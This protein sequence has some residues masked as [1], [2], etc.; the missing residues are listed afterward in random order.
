MTRRSPILLCILIFMTML[1]LF[2]SCVSDVPFP[3]ENPSPSE[4]SS[5]TKEPAIDIEVPE[6]ISIDM[7]G[8]ASVVN[9]GS[10]ALKVDRY[11]ALDTNQSYAADQR[12][13]LING[14]LLV[15]AKLLAKIT[16]FTFDNIDG[17]NTATLTL[18][19]TVVTF[20]A[21][22]NKISIDGQEYTYPTIIKLE[23]SFLL[24]AQPFVEALGYTFQYD[25]T[26]KTY[27]ISNKTDSLTEEVRTALE[28]TSIQYDTIVY[29]YDDVECGQSGVGLYDKTPYEDRLVGIAY[30]TW[31]TTS[32]DWGNKTWDIPL[33]GKYTSNTK[34]IIRAHGQMLAEAGVDFIFIDW[35]NNTSYDPETMSAS[36]NDFRTIEQ[37]TDIIFEEWAKI[38]NAPKICIFVGPGHSGQENVDN[39]NHQ[40]KVDQVYRDY[41]D[42]PENKD[43]Y[44]YYKGKP[45]L[46]CYAATPTKYG[47][48]PEW[49]DER[50]TI[51]WMTGFV[52]QQSKLF[53]A[54]TK[55]SYRYWSWEERGEQTFTVVDGTVEA[56]TCCAASRKQSNP[57]DNNYIAPIPRNNG[58][59]LKQQFQRACDL[60][61]GVVV[62]VS[63]NEW[64]IGEQPSAE[65]SK[66]IEPSKIYG[67]FYYDLMR[68]QIRKFKGKV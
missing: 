48:D 36:R 3:T 41:I 46:I 21:G 24:S 7:S 45:L 59:T 25:D 16:G 31:H 14:Q 50:F 2:T 29:N 32:R 30:S 64:S 8:M 44:F 34:K 20:S 39:G 18:K 58:M 17:D 55:R 10:F 26:L 13:R 42:N 27:Y 5:P 60:G 12:T 66:D 67:T 15:D 43:M 54:E 47:V 53:E 1:I 19:A 56:I 40:K 37:S 9:K 62:I 57:G 4:T 38:P 68:E 61:A 65:V 28:E 52:G 11:Y 51:R 33:L 22:E 63:W 49:T 35:S 6:N 23:N